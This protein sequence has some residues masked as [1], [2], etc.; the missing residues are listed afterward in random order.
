MEGLSINKSTFHHI[1]HLLIMDVQGKRD[2]HEF[3]VF[4]PF[5]DAVPTA[6]KSGYFFNTRKWVN[7]Y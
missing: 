6:V 1:N 5:Q 7:A 3:D 2:V 4:S